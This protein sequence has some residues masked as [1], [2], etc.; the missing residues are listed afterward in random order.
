MTGH[1]DSMAPTFGPGDILLVDR[2]VKS[3]EADAIYVFT[4]NTELFIKRLQRQIA[5]GLLMISDNTRYAAQLIP[6]EEM[7]EVLKAHGDVYHGGE[8]ERVQLF[9]PADWL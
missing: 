1:G 6:S 4:H 2:G 3:V 9:A 8:P 5:G 7:I